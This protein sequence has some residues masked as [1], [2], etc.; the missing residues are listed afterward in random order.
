MKSNQPKELAKL[1]K[2][3]QML[4]EARS[5]D[6]VKEILDKSKA[7]ETYARAAKL[8]L[9]AQNYA[10]EI[11]LRAE[12]KAGELLRTLSRNKEGRPKKLSNNGRFSEYD[13]VLK[14]T[15]TSKQDASRWE[16]I[17]RLP[18]AEFDRYIAQ[19]QAH[20]KELPTAG[21]LRIAKQVDLEAKRDENAEKIAAMPPM[22][23]VVA[24]QVFTTMVIDP[25]WEFG[26]EGGGDLFDRAKPPY[27]T[28]PFEEILAL[29]VAKYA[30]KNAHLYLWITNQLLPKGFALLESWG[31]RYI[32]CLTW[33]KPNYR[34]G[35]YFRGQTEQVLFGVKGS[36]PL[37]RNDAPTVFLA[38]RGTGGHSSK[39]NEFYE[40]VETCSPASYIDVFARIERKGWTSI[41]GEVKRA[42]AHDTRCSAIELLTPALER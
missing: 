33:V 28:M 34:M 14:Y 17:E 2:A 9:V 8:G 6:Q 13:R 1:N 22:F 32:T 12:R 37:L 31:F 5:L 42:T 21:A 11:T 15:G 24:G 40:L 30:D 3:A 19:T 23:S 16:Q 41:G 4:A 25:P 29:P 36:L 10:A 35:N 38:P 26:D 27:A 18:Q 7:A 39:P 20:E